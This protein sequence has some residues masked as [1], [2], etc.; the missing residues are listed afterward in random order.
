MNEDEGGGLKRRHE[1]GGRN[2]NSILTLY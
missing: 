1:R 2:D